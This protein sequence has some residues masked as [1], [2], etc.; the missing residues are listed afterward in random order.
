VPHLQKPS[1][2]T[3]TSVQ[4]VNRT[5]KEHELEI[6]V[7]TAAIQDQGQRA[8]SGQAEG[9]LALVEGFLDNYRVLSRYAEPGVL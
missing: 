5:E 3:L 9:Y 4:G 8:A 7:S 1:E 2:T 6:E